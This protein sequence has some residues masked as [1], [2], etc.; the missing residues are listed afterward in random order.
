[1]NYPVG[2]RFRVVFLSLFLTSLPA[3]AA[4][5]NL[6]SGSSRGELQTAITSA[7]A[8]DTIGFPAGDGVLFDN[9]AAAVTINKAGLSLQGGAPSGFATGIGN[10][11][12]ALT[13]G[14]SGSIEASGI[15]SAIQGYIGSADATLGA[16]SFISAGGSVRNP[17]NPDYHYNS[18][19][20]LSMAVTPNTPYDSLANGF[21]FSDL[22]F[23]GVNVVYSDTYIVNG[24]I[25]NVNTADRD[26]GLG[27]LTG[28]AL[29]HL[30]VTLNGTLDTQYLAG[31]GVIGV[32]STSNA[33][34][35]GNIVGNFFNDVSVTAQ[36]SGSQSPYLEGGGLIGLNAASSPSETSQGQAR[37]PLLENNLFTD[38]RIHSGD[39]ILGGGLIGL[40]NNSKR[41]TGGTLNPGVILDRASGNVFGNGEDGDIRVTSGYSLRGGG[42]IGLNGLSSAAVQLGE[43]SGNAFDGVTV[44]AGSYIKGGGLVG[45][46]TNDGGRPGAGQNNDEAKDSEAPKAASATLGSVSNNLF[47]NADVTAQTYLYGGG[48]VGLRSN[49]GRSQ[50]VTLESNVFQDINVSAGGTDG[51]AGNS[52]SGGGI[53]GVSSKEQGNITSVH[54]NLFKDL[55]VSAAGHLSGGGI[56]GAEADDSSSSSSFA[57]INNVTD[58][59]FSDLDVET[60]AGGA[61]RG[62]GILGVETQG[63]ANGLANV[64]GNRFDGLDV[65]SDS[66]LSGGGVVGVQV[67]N[68]YAVLGFLDRNAFNGVNVSADEYIKGGGIVGL[69]SDTGKNE[70]VFNMD[71]VNGNV[72]QNLEVSV[73]GTDGSG[74]SLY[75]GGIVGVSSG[76]QGSVANTQ[77]NHFIDLMVSMAGNLYGGGIL[78]AQADGG[79]SS[80]AILSEITGNVFSGLTVG[81]TSSGA[82]QG[83][84]IVGVQNLGG[85]INGLKN[86]AGN[87][88][89]NLDVSSA[90]SLSGGGIVGASSGTKGSVAT[91]SGN[92][93]GNLTVHAAGDLNGGGVVGVE[94]EDSAVLGEV[95]D[96][97]FL[98][99][100]TV[101]S[102]GAIRGG[103]IVGAR[104]DG[105]AGVSMLDTVDA[106]AFQSLS[107]EAGEIAGGGIVGVSSR[108][109]GSATKVSGNEFSDLTVST[110]GKLLG[111]GIVGAQAQANDTSG[112]AVLD[113]VTGNIFS[114]LTVSG[115]AIQG[116]GIVGVQN[117]GGANGLRNASGN[118]YD[119]LSVHSSASL[120][121]GGIVGVWA[122]KG[123]A[124][125]DTLTNSFFSRINV[126]A[127]EYIEGGG[128]VGVRSNT[129]GSI[130]TIDNVWFSGLTVTAG[131]Y[132]DGG[133]IVGATGPINNTGN[134]SIGIHNIV[135]SVF[136]GN[137]IRANDG[138]IMGG[139]VYSYGL[140]GGLTIQDSFFVDNRF[141]STVS[142]SYGGGI[143]PRVYG[144]VTVD[145]GVAAPF[146]NTYTL[147][148]KATSSGN[149]MFTGNVI[150]EGDT[151][152]GSNSLYFGTIPELDGLKLDGTLSAQADAAE[153]NAKLV[154]DTAPGGTVALYDPVEVNQNNGQTFHML[155]QG[156]GYF[157][158]AGE[159]RF[160]VDAPGTVT[161]NSSTTTFL[162]G[163]S[164]DAPKHSFSLA[165]K[166]RI[167]VQGEN[168]MTLASADLNGTLA[169]N[170]YRTTVNEADTA[171]LTLHT[172]QPANLEGS[173]VQLSSFKAGGPILQGGDRFYLIRSDAAGD[174]QGDPRNNHAYARQGLL[175]GYNFIIDKQPLYGSEEGE[176]QYLVAR[177]EEQKAQTD[178]NPPVYYPPKD[179][180]ISPQIDQPDEPQDTP[181]PPAPPAPPVPVV[182]TPDDPTPSP[183]P[184]PTPKPIPDPQPTPLEPVD[185]DQ[186]VQPVPV[187]DIPKVDPDT[188]V[189]PT[190]VDPTPV[191][192]IPVDPTP[193]DPTPVDPTPVDPT[194]VD[195]TP[196]DPTPVDPNPPA[197][198]P[199]YDPA[200][201]TT[202]LV[203]GRAA[204]LAFLAQ[205]GGWLADHSYQA[206]DLALNE[207]RGERAW[208]PFGGV[209]VGRWRLDTGSRIKLSSSNM[210]LG[211]ATRRRGD[212]G[213]A[214]LGIFLEAGKADYDTRN[215]F[216]YLQSIDGDGD[217]DAIGGGLMARHTWNND[218]RI[219]A[220]LRTGRL[221][222]DFRTKNYE[223]ENGVPTRY[224]STD[225]YLAAHLGVG[226][227][228][229]VSEKNNLDL[230]LRYYW[231]RLEGSKVTLSDSERIRL[232]DN[233]SH[234]I[235]IG[236][237]LTHT[238]KENRFWYVGAAVERELDSKVKVN[239]IVK[240]GAGTHVFALDTHDF[241][242]TT[243]IGEIGVIIRSR[244]N[245]PFSLEAGVQ[246][247]AGKF[248]GVSGGIRIGWEF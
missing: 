39:I 232:H 9:T 180:P 209:D 69:R 16:L 97:S 236:G 36:G 86:V 1:M 92:Y 106:N 116:G 27:N 68:G 52:L 40:N 70:D 79:A 108:Q 240:D 62:G 182:P 75:G 149:T 18:S 66:S 144:A 141:Y 130:G 135:D 44:D 29:T 193:V 234:R 211:L 184:S 207:N 8:G 158:W 178:P 151:F 32:R 25:G 140:A 35:A 7:A 124:V 82:I 85:G 220:S 167:N 181:T 49:A 94:A 23:T 202:V 129:A 136:T 160:T 73:N 60:T 205:R 187:P 88:F 215:H 147:T 200:N 194:P 118:R 72:F 30:S 221:K 5:A 4:E 109:Q 248:K 153:A 103:G 213:V 89:D 57:V 74:A 143:G 43:L 171:L 235:R 46:H 157:D 51:S 91:I 10:L 31:G 100:L 87:H 28:N 110:A 195:P 203:G 245:S 173:T 139:L 61:I 237:R 163:F 71:R 20:W 199:R 107:V 192:P 126:S 105:D 112:F 150:Y 229:Q 131:T 132:I 45:L 67:T 208:V 128:I 198:T 47:L 170:L 243:S 65:H 164:L 247:Y 218:F 102:G 231:T 133:G 168:S 206:A 166:A 142:S 238:W 127:D 50:L 138:Q 176:N 78:G 55:Y 83:G 125:L 242:G 216:A 81:T 219:E 225:H 21:A 53:V 33:A 84:G 104:A 146:D 3:W 120:S 174:L 226:R 222:N 223:D 175:V 2:R 155:V 11:S 177:L 58:N 179:D 224:K 191:D 172:A 24:L 156:G 19:K 12:S 37:L 113:E 154:I 186:P 115:G 6:A 101:T 111:G 210:L 48:I 197:P 244:K 54:N 121:G 241:K 201:E 64:G 169:F 161:L 145:T 80:S 26:T 63:G 148:L 185:P 17:G 123:Y 122:D 239:A 41:D 77:S 188:P 190:P 217:L 183:T 214:L 13:Q 212:S 56:L 189:D 134:L 76:T 159:N 99:P 95:R 14:R 246:G 137:T 114:N 96:N 227:G 98:A 117:L 38:I 204:G 15:A 42:V 59:T 119:Q 228:W 233:D 93:F 90:S 230:L 162:T 165:S 22:H 196:V 152:R 34:Y